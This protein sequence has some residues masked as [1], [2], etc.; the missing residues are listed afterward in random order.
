MNILIT[1]G[2]GYIAST[3]QIHLS[4]HHNVTCISRKD[5]DLTVSSEVNTFF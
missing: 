1:G 2:D 3:L 5:L 4:A